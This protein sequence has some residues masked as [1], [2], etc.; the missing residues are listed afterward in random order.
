MIVKG[1]ESK[2]DDRM[3]AVNVDTVNERL[4]GLVALLQAV[5]VDSSALNQGDV[6]RVSKLS[7]GE[8]GG[9]PD[10][11]QLDDK[12]IEAIIKKLQQAQE[13]APQIIAALEAHS[14]ARSLGGDKGSAKPSRKPQQEQQQQHV[15]EEEDDDDD[16][17][18]EYDEDGNYPMVGHGCSDD[19]SVMSDLT[20]P[21]VV[22]DSHVA[23]EE[24]YR[25]DPLPPMIIGGGGAPA[26]VISAPKRKNLVSQVRPGQ[27]GGAPP[28]RGVGV[29]PPRSGAKPGAL[30]SRRKNY[31]STMAKL[32]DNPTGFAGPTPTPPMKRQ[33]SSRRSS[34]GPGGPQAGAAPKKRV[35]KP[36][37][38]GTD[39]FSDLAGSSGADWDALDQNGWDTGFEKKPKSQPPKSPKKPTMIDDD[40]FLVGGSFEPFGTGASD[41]FK[42]SAGDL[43]HNSRPARDGFSAKASTGATPGAAPIRKTRPKRPEQ[44][45]APSGQPGE[46]APVRRVRPAG[47]G[48]APANGRPVRRSRRASLM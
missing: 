44:R 11:R 2:A 46:A 21:T 7:K 34:T 24:H 43:E 31:Q 38:N 32:Q 3:S 26:M 1:R 18:D 15:E 13:E 12:Q 48:P 35:P 40:G 27:I 42:S 37:G 19:Y 23:D 45:S 10:A 4:N 39:N 29:P 17:D 22:N 20:T 36:R 41:P 6:D 9:M 28:R 14:S 33:P 16:D 25:H 8:I 5:G 47:T 30:A